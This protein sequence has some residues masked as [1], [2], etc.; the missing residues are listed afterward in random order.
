MIV[1][2]FVP[3]GAIPDIRGFAPAIVAQNFYK[4]FSA[5]I[6][7]YFVSGLEHCE[8]KEEMTEFGKVFRIGESKIYK[9]LFQKITKLDPYPLYKRLAKIINQNPVDILHIHQ[10]E[11]PINKFKK[12]LKNKQTK[13]ISHAHVISNKFVENRGVANC[14][15]ASSRFTQKMMKEQNYYPNNLIQTISNGVNIN[16][17]KPTNNDNKNHIK[18]SLNIS[19]DKIIISFV[20]RKQ[21]G[22]GFEVFLQVAE[23]I[24]KRYDN[25]IFL[26]AGQEPNNSETKILSLRRKLKNNYIDLPPLEHAQLNTIYQ[27]SDITL[28]PTK[29]EAQGMTVVESISCGCITISNK[30][31]GVIDTI[32]DGY[33]GFFLDNSND[34]EKAISKVKYVIN[35]LHRLDYI[36]KNARKVAVEKFD[37]KVQTQKLEQVYKEVYEQN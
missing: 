7:H 8:T 18:D 25:I 23:S 37:W 22:K 17:F 30:V 4:Y 24:L 1:C 36:R 5:D 15:I 27:I 19:K 34:V 29:M 26:A 9:R 6:K 13:I 21:T 31:G 32:I 11:F 28:L 14:Y 12:L 10:L 35:N 16:L 20:G 33:N 2:Q 3:H